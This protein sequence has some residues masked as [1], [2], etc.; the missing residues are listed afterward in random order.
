MHAAH[1][2]PLVK[3]LY[4]NSNFEAAPAVSDAANTMS[5]SSV[6]PKEMSV[7]NEVYARTQVRT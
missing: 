2:L 6:A 3:Y 7:S 1:A 5:R 4:A